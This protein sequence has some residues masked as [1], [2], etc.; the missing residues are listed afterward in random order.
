MTVMM[1]LAD[2]DG[3]LKVDI[4]EMSDLAA[5]KISLMVFSTWS[6]TGNGPGGAAAAAWPWPRR[7]C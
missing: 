5:K 4:K 2:M 3:C 6:E 7:E 1:G